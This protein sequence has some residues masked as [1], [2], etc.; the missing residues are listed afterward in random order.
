VIAQILNVVTLPTAFFLRRKILKRDSGVCDQ[1]V[2]TRSFVET[3]SYS[4]SIENKRS[5]STRLNCRSEKFI[6]KN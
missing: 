4:K 3:S 1:R 2:N 5:Q 6:S